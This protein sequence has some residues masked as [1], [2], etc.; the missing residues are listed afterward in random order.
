MR[1]GKPKVSDTQVTHGTRSFHSQLPCQ[2]VKEFIKPGHKPTLPDDYNIVAGPLDMRPLYDMKAKDT[3]WTLT[4]LDLE[5]KP[6]IKPLQQKVPSWSG[7]NAI[8]TEEQIPITKSCFAPL[9]PFPVTEYST[10]YTEMKNLQEVLQVLDQQ[11]TAVTCDEGVYQIARE[12]QLLRPEEF[13]NIVLCMGSF[14]MAKV[15]LGCTGKYLKRKW[16]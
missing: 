15:A 2:K 5:D 10:V 8:W 9:L 6:N 13:S 7:T 4:R 1:R 16:G 11:K 12:I 3:I 14:H